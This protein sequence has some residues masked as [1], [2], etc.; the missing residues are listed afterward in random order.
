MEGM[1]LRFPHIGEG[2][3]KKLLNKRLAKC[4]EVART[5]E[6]FI[7]NEK[8]YRQK[9]KY[10]TIQKRKTGIYGN[11]HLHKAAEDG[12]FEECK[13]IIAYVEDKNPP[14]DLERTPLH[15]AARKGHFFIFKLIFDNI[16]HKNPR[17]G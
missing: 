15:L 4:K 8:F 13:L 17:Q 12:Q 1:F 2:I 16:Q 6:H 11:T 10:E 14:N 7:I 5:W 9:V 3:I